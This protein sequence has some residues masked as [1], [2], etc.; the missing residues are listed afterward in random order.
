[1]R[2]SHMLSIFHAGKFDRGAVAPISL[3]HDS[4]GSSARAVTAAAIPGHIADDYIEGI[5]KTSHL[6]ATTR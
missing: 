2:A 4:F 6:C 3:Y 1:M 5:P